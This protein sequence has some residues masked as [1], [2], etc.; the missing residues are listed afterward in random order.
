MKVTI[1]GLEFETTRIRTGC[2]KYRVR[3]AGSSIWTDG[4]DFMHGRPSEPKTQKT[5]YLYG[6]RDLERASLK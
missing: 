1:E 4:S 5:L 2:F 3:R 6:K